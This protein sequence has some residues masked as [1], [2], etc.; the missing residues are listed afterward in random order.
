MINVLDDWVMLLHPTIIISRRSTSKLEEDVID[1]ITNLN[2]IDMR[3][4]Q[5][6]SRIQRNNQTKKKKRRKKK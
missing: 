4:C 3:H 6:I 5:S 1:S 2:V